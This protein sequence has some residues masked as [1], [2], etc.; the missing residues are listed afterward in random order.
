MISRI[1]LKNEP[2]SLKQFRK[3][4]FKFKTQQQ[5]NNKARVLHLKI[6]HK[7]PAQMFIS[8]KNPWNSINE[9]LHFNNIQ[10]PFINYVSFYSMRIDASFIFF[11]QNIVTEVSTL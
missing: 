3:N 1:T 5:S 11:H 2:I 8:P 9:L 7:I 4:K 6:L 10:A